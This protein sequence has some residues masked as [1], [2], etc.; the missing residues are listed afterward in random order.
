MVARA[1]DGRAEAV[2]LVLLQ[3]RRTDGGAGWHLTAADR[4]P[5]RVGAAR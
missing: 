4:M 5:S 1:T 3:Q 2:V